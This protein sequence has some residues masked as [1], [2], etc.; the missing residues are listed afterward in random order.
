MK[1][2]IA[3]CLH[4]VIYKN[5]C[6][7]PV[8]QNGNSMNQYLSSKPGITNAFANVPSTFG[9]MNCVP[10]TIA[11]EPTFNMNYIP[12]NFATGNAILA[13]EAITNANMLAN[14]NSALANE[15]IGNAVISSANFIPLA[16]LPS[17]FA[18]NFPMSPIISE[19][20]PSLQ[21]G[22]ITMG[23]DLPIGGTI[24]VCGC[25]PVY[26]M[27]TVDGSVPSAGTA[28]VAES[29]SKPGMP[30]PGLAIL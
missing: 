8:L 23:G 1:F 25:F 17:G 14:A 18:N 7:M 10:N 28:V 27:V 29:F 16:N 19:I 6:S 4:A 5:V 22:D 20:V 2:I 24:K 3:I 30:C 15:M 12:N 9:N 26:G 11:N 13:N 21:Y